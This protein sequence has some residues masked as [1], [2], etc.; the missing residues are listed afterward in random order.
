MVGSFLQQ[1]GLLAAALLLSGV[2]PVHVD[3]EFEPPAE[4]HRALVPFDMARNRT[5]IVVTSVEGGATFATVEITNAY[6]ILPVGTEQMSYGVQLQPIPR[7]F[8]D[9]RKRLQLMD[10]HHPPSPLPVKSPFEPRAA[11]HRHLRPPLLQAWQRVLLI[12]AA[13]A[14]HAKLAGGYREPRARRVASQREA[15]GRALQMGRRRLRRLSGD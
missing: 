3:P 4:V 8:D 7:G 13:D 10:H 2:Q 12:C 1:L 11:G 14:P 6:P 9:V 15:H 5:N